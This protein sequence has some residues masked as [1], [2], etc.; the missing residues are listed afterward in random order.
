MF[1]LSLISWTEFLCTITILGVLY[2]LFVYLYFKYLSKQKQ[3]NL[4]IN[5]ENK[6]KSA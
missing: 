2:N 4:E 5:R 6:F 3:V 1:S